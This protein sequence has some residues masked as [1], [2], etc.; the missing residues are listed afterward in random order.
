LKGLYKP[1]LPARGKLL[2]AGE[3]VETAEKTTPCCFP[4][5][6]TNLNGI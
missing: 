3:S 1:L 6:H 5:R 2:A 4:F